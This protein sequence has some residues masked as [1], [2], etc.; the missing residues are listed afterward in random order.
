MIT[1]LLVGG[2]GNQLVLDQV[3][4][5]D[6]QLQP[7]LSSLTS[8][9]AWSLDSFGGDSD[10]VGPI[11]AKVV[12]LL[13]VVFIGT[14]LSGLAGQSTASF[15]AG[16]G[17]VMVS[18]ALA[19]GVFVAA[20]DAFALDGALADAAGGAIPLV[21]GGVND[22]VQFG[23]YTGWLIGLA[24]VITSRRVAPEPDWVAPVPISPGSAPGYPTVYPK[25]PSGADWSAPPAQQTGS[26]ASVY[27]AMDDRV[28]RMGA[29]AAPAPV[30]A[31]APVYGYGDE[32]VDQGAMVDDDHT[33]PASAPR[34]QPMWPDQWSGTSSNRRRPAVGGGAYSRTGKDPRR[35]SWTRWSSRGD[36]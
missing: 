15:L 32:A 35:P 33:E 28:P 24:V 5:V 14:A 11:V 1:A 3:V 2:L 13:V 8:F 25:L 23:L 19:G 9:P 10:M 20:A 29:T 26:T 36:D 21:V 18:A 4:E 6:G 34:A 16:W 22:G 30:T 17:S 12:L 7:L 27:G 31:A